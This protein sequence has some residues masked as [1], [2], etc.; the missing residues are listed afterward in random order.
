M[1]QKINV[2]RTLAV[3]REMPVVVIAGQTWVPLVPWLSETREYP[4]IPCLLMGHQTLRQGY[5][6]WAIIVYPAIS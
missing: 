1:M 4:R 3:L 5:E 2:G 6:S